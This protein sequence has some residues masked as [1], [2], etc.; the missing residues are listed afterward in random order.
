MRIY[1]EN[2]YAN[3]T[4]VSYIILQLSKIFLCFKMFPFAKD[5]WGHFLQGV[6]RLWMV[7]PKW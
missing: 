1:L 6:L 3:V 5:T 2:F 4:S 7:H